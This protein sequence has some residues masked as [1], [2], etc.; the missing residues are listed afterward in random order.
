MYYEIFY[1]PTNSRMRNNVSLEIVSS[2]FNWQLTDQRRSS[3]I[4]KAKLA[5]LPHI[6]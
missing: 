5:S 2:D 1:Y 6:V 4:V 3:Q